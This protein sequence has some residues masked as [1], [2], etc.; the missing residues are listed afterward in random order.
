[1]GSNFLITYSKTHKDI[2]L[3]GIDA[4]REVLESDHI[5]EKRSLLF[6]MD[7]YLDSYYGY[8]LPYKKDILS[9]LEEELFLNEDKD[10]KDDILQLLRSYTGETLDYLAEKISEL[11][12]EPEL[13]ANALYALGNTCNMKYIKILNKYKNDDNAIIRDSVKDILTEIQQEKA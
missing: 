4:I 9:L 2:V 11:E 10:V 8:N 12:Y 3:S 7:K 1:M 13:L 6:C 5:E